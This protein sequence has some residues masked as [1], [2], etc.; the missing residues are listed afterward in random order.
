M[1][2]CDA[3]EIGGTAPGEMRPCDPEMIEKLDEGRLDRRFMLRFCADRYGCSSVFGA[4][5]CMAKRDLPTTE[6]MV[7]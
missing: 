2:G 4:P 7:R 3:L 6:A 5:S 1:L